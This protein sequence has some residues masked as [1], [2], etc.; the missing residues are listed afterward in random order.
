MAVDAVPIGVS[1]T[2]L[3]PR[4]GGTFNVRAG[5]AG[6]KIPFGMVTDFNKG[7]RA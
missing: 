3:H 7:Y 6:R 2:V 1:R 4:I 5:G